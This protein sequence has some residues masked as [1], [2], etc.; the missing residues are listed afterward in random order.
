MRNVLVLLAT[1]FAVSRAQ[2][3][4]TVNDTDSSIQVR[5]RSESN[6]SPNLTTDAV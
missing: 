1:L 5:S 4:I 6:N 3:N 2:H